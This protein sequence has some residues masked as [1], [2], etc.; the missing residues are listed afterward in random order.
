MTGMAFMIFGRPVGKRD[1][2]KAIPVMLHLRLLMTEA[3]STVSFATGKAILSPTQTG[4][5]VVMLSHHKYSCSAK[6]N[7]PGI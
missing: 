6:T 3:A 5:V 2:M 1:I 4:V 7:V